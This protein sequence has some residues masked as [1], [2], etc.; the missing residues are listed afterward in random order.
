MNQLSR[1]KILVSIIAILLV[2]NLVMLVLFFKV[3]KHSEKAQKKLG[4]TEKLRTEVGFTSE[5]MSVYEPGKTEF[6]KEYRDRFEEIKKTKE[7]FYFQ[8]YDS[9]ITDSVLESKAE[10]IGDQQKEIDLHVVRYFKE[11][12]KLCTPKQLPKYDSLLPAIVERMTARP[13]RK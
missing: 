3:C 6:W 5:Q 1:N 8:M 12:R 11:V 13:S 2:T 10:V 4:F 9:T 7:D